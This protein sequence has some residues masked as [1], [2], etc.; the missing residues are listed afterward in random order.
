MVAGKRG[1]GVCG[2]YPLVGLNLLAQLRRRLLVFV[3]DGQ[4]AQD[5]LQPVRRQ[6]LHQP[7]GEDVRAAAPINLVISF[8]A[9][10][11]NRQ[12][13]VPLVRQPKV[14][15]TKLYNAFVEVG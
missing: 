4:A 3:A 8:P 6:Y 12:V 15:Q 7:H 5:G 9:A 2:Q 13:G 14:G 1:V 11:R 10:E